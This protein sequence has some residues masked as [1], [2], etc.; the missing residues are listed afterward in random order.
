LKERDNA[1]VISDQ[2][3]AI[4]KQIITKSKNFAKY[5]YI[6]LFFLCWLIKKC[7]LCTRN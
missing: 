7:Y 4:T 6:Y 2:N 5:A 3:T 1:C